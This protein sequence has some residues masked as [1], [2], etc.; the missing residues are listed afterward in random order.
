[1]IGYDAT[2]AIGQ[3]IAAREKIYV[4]TLT[5]MAFFYKNLPLLSFRLESNEII[6]AKLSEKILEY[7]KFYVVSTEATEQEKNEQ[8]IKKYFTER[9]MAKYYLAAIYYYEPTYDFANANISEVV[10]LGNAYLK[11][12]FQEN[13]SS[14]IS[15]A[16]QKATGNAN[17]IPDYKEKWKYFAYSM[18]KSQYN[19]EYLN[20]VQQ[21]VCYPSRNTDVLFATTSGKYSSYF[22]NIADFLSEDRDSIPNDEVVN[23]YIPRFD[24]KEIKSSFTKE[25]WNDAPNMIQFFVIDSSSNI[26]DINSRQIDLYKKQKLN[27]ANSFISYYTAYNANT[28]NFDI[29]FPPYF[30]QEAGSTISQELSTFFEFSFQPNY[31]KIKELFPQINI[32]EKSFNLLKNSYFL[33]LSKTET[34]DFMKNL[35][36]DTLISTITEEQFASLFDLQVVLLYKVSQKYISKDFFSSTKPTDKTSFGIRSWGYSD[37]SYSGVSLLYNPLINPDENIAI[38][39]QNLKVPK[40]TSNRSLNLGNALADFQIS[41]IRAFNPYYLFD[42][43]ELLDKFINIIDSATSEEAKIIKNS[44]ETNLDYNPFD[45]STIAGNFLAIH[46]SEL[47]ERLIDDNVNLYTKTYSQFSKNLLENLITNAD[48]VK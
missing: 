43:N 26:F 30:N 38:T 4:F 7:F 16:K 40:I 32:S 3:S 9:A 20:I 21:P 45:Y 28:K 18:L 47:P 46:T 11:Q 31:E 13:I 37:S 24:N 23:V 33:K 5:Y 6:V 22:A 48:K 35:V 10:E 36:G 14:F 8:Q 25:F 41:S 29:R 15:K 12:L 1:M 42:N 19:Q 34:Y 27:D 39:S 17:T 2:N 44:F